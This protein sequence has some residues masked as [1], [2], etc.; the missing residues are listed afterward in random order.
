MLTSTF[1]PL[2][3]ATGSPLIL[4]VSPTNLP[5]ET[6]DSFVSAAV[7]ESL[8]D[9]TSASPTNSRV[10]PFL[11]SICLPVAKALIKLASAI[12]VPFFSAVIE[13]LVKVNSSGVSKA[14]M[15]KVAPT[16]V[17]EVSLP[18]VIAPLAIVSLDPSPKVK[19]AA[20]FTPEVASGPTFKEAEL[21]PSP[22]TTSTLSLVQVPFTT[23]SLE[24][25]SE[26]SNLP[27][28]TPSADTISPDWLNKASAYLA[29][30]GSPFKVG[31]ASS[32]CFLIAAKSPADKVTNL[33]LESSP[34]TRS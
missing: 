17:E 28:A 21:E 27:L 3:K 33:T 14:E 22:R 9:S 13:P 1:A 7:P 32:T 5:P 2:T 8:V 15:S 6:T 31:L 30:K 4:R 23:S 10:P 16:K 20:F 34:T 25:S 24:P 18:T 26:R 19:A 12:M 29:F 11:T